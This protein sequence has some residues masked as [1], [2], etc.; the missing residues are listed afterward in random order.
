MQIT[1][2]ILIQDVGYFCNFICMLWVVF[3][4]SRCLRVWD[5]AV[6]GVKNFIIL[7]FFS[8]NLPYGVEGCSLSCYFVFWNT[9]VNFLLILKI[10]LLHTHPQL[11]QN[12]II[13]TQMVW[14]I[15]GSQ[16]SLS[17]SYDQK[18]NS[19]LQ[20]NCFI[21]DIIILICDSPFSYLKLN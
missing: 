7:Y 12:R 15:G 11:Q 2:I 6:R 1:W 13:A 18:Q 8:E 14:G 10:H 3:S 5:C 16:M 9:V 17:F 4:L 20:L 19:C 21:L